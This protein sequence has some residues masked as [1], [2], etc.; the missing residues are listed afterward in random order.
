MKCP[1]QDMRYW[2]P[3][4]IFEVECPKCSGRVEFFKDDTARKCPACG[5][6]FANPE[7]DFGCAAHCRYAE[8]CLGTLPPELAARRESLLKDKIAVAVKRRLGK[9]FRRIGRAVRAA[10]FAEEI[11][12]AAGADPGL[13]LSAAYLAEA[14]DTPAVRR[15]IA[16]EVL[17]AA[18]APNEMVQQVA[19]IV[20][21]L[22][23]KAETPE[24]EAV[25]DALMLS[26]AEAARIHGKE[27]PV[28]AKALRTDA[29]KQM[30][31]EITASA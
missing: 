6:R 17:E 5:H 27:S 7:M 12:V 1:G 23:E 4:A 10:R 31:T 18:G 19:R 21:D 11:A 16:E 20:E 25:A 29:G 13:V 26:V 24:A 30:L 15:E 3:G 2:K 28:S 22:P 8:Q 14:D 9:D